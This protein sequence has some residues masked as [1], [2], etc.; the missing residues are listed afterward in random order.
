MQTQITTGPKEKQKLQRSPLTLQVG[1]QSERKER[2]RVRR[3]RLACTPAPPGNQPLG[4]STLPR[5]ETL[6]TKRRRSCL[7]SGDLA[8]RKRNGCP[9]ARE[10]DDEAKKTAHLPLISERRRSSAEETAHR[11]PTS[12]RR[13]SSKPVDE[14][15]HIPE[16]KLGDLHRNTAEQPPPRWLTQQQPRQDPPFI[17]REDKSSLLGKL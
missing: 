13:S 1:P 3:L 16:N 4:M 2:N 9:S 11:S 15:T 5:P 12:R 14:R 17:A 10:F 8:G 6:T 7:P